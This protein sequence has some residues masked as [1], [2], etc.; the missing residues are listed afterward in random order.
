MNDETPIHDDG[1]DDRE[2]DGTLRGNQIDEVELLAIWMAGAEVELR[3]MELEK[4]RATKVKA[5]DPYHT[6]KVVR[7][8]MKHAEEMYGGPNDS[9]LDLETADEQGVKAVLAK[10]AAAFDQDIRDRKENA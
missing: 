2:E 10:F 4:K 1:F 9:G 3:Q 7:L 6:R 5:D 8:A